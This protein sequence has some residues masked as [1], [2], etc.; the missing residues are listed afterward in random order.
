MIK[1]LTVLG[2]RPEVIKLAP[3]I[4]EFNSRNAIESVVCSTGQ[5]L[6]MLSTAVSAFNIHLDY[7][8][9]LM[10]ES[11]ALAGLTGRAVKSVNEVVT[12]EDPD[13]VIVQ[14]DTT[15]SFVG[16]LAGFY[17]RVPVGHVEA[18]LRS[19]DMNNPFPEEINR[20]LADVLSSYYFAPTKKAK[21]N[22]ITEG[23]SSERIIITGNTVIDALKRI[24]SAVESG[25]VSPGLPPEI[26]SLLDDSE[27]ILLV[28][29]HRRESQDG[30]IAGVCRAIAE[31]VNLYPHMQVVFPVHLNPKVRE[32]VFEI[33]GSLD[34]VSLIEPQDYVG[35]VTLMKHAKLILTDS[36]GIQEEAPSLGVPVLVAREK[37]E[38]PE[39]IESGTAKLVGTDPKVIIREVGT[40]WKNES[41]YRTMAN[42]VN[43]FGSGDAAR[44][45]S[46]YIEER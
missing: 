3:V 26:S 9:G 15:T 2:T 37:T 41:A 39:A 44:K 42:R 5:H 6:E 1:T 28:T 19:G 10:E 34:R 32:P 11:Q 24:S 13:V 46:D 17:N 29:T 33:L 14:G 30:G 27:E 45:I 23:F 18:G 16:A 31:L 22:L 40:L 25:D 20:R 35:F 12:D 4:E 43:P 8:L 38:R 21:R 36:G 7:D